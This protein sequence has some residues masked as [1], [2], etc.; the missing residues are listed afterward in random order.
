MSATRE[1]WVNAYAPPNDAFFVG[2]FRHFS[3]EAADK[4]V[5]NLRN[6]HSP[7]WRVPYRIHVKMKPE[8][9]AMPS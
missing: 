8:C 9:E 2:T 1:F 6:G 3:R 5:S 7:E 4:S